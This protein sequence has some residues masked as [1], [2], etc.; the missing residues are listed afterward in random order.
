MNYTIFLDSIAETFRTAINTVPSSTPIHTP[1]FG[2]TNHRY[3]SEVFRLAHIERYTDNKIEVL[4][5]T[6]FPHGW[7]PEPIF[8]FDVIC[9]DNQVV[10]VYLDFTPTFHPYPFSGDFLERKPLPEWATVFSQDF[11]LLKPI[12]DLEFQSFCGWAIHQYTK[13][14]QILLQK[15]KFTDTEHLQMVKEK[16]NTYCHIQASNPRTYT[17]LKHKIGEEKA[18]YFMQQILFPQIV[19]DK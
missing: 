13:Y 3:E 18:T 19:L 2:W 5:I 7:S 10:G 4:H 12:N 8:G 6:T 16:Q 14:L 15:E 17:V 1:D 11:I 9:T